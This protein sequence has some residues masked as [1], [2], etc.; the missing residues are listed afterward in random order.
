MTSH[1]GT[2]WDKKYLKEKK[3][4]K[5]NKSCLQDEVCLRTKTESLLAYYDTSMHMLMFERS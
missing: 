4:T 1:F 3:N 5:Q 2:L